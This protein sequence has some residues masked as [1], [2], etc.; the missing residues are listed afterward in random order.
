MNFK[1][2]YSTFQKKIW[3][4]QFK[5]WVIKYKSGVPNEYAKKRLRFPM[6]CMWGSSMLKLQRNADSYVDINIT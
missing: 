1:H 5:A 4:L 6:K 3:G 2:I